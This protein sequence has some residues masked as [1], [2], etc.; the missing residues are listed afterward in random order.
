MVLEIEEDGG[1]GGG[2]REKAEVEVLIS[3]Q[4]CLRRGGWSEI[5]DERGGQYASA[6]AFRRLTL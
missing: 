4:S 5:D 1:A 2:L 3:I 6:V